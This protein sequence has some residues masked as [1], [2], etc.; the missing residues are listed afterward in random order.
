M[1]VAGAFVLTDTLGRSFDRLF[2]EVYADTDVHVTAMPK[3]DRVGEDGERSRHDR[4]GRPS[5]GS[6]TVAGV[7]GATGVVTPTAPG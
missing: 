7:A 4:P 2:A 5:T 6:A 1:F 3:V